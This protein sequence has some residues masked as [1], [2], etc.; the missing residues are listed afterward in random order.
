MS[1]YKTLAN[2]TLSDDIFYGEKVDYADIQSAMRNV[3]AATKELDKIKKLLFYGKGTCTVGYKGCRLENK[4][5]KLSVEERHILHGA[6]GMATEAGEVLE[7]I[8]KALYSFF[9]GSG[10]EIDKPNLIEEV[11]DCSW[12]EAAI[13]K[14][15]SCEMKDF[16]I[17]NIKKLSVRYPEKF[18]TALAN[19]RNLEA[20]RKS[21]EKSTKELTTKRN[22]RK[23]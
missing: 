14:G 1:N 23:V 8:D 17:A 16:Q 20:E 7:C 19:N 10:F 5:R 4:T 15:L 9:N 3:I 2:R 22:K 18:T 12:Y 13:A 11:G 21:L 6:I